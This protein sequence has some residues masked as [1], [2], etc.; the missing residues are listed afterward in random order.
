MDEISFEEWS[1][2]VST[3][4]PELVVSLLE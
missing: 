3:S 4:E 1:H 2:C